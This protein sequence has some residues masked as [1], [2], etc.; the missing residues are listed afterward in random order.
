M[1]GA[2]PSAPFACAPR[3]QG[4]KKPSRAG[5]DVDPDNQLMKETYARVD[6]L[7]RKEGHGMAGQPLLRH[8]FP[9]SRG[10]R[11]CLPWFFS[12]A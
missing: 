7:E 10:L 8:F 9:V 6:A 11:E 3:A 2:Q 12:E 1:R 4:L 5:L